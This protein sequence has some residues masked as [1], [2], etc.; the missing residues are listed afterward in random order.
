MAENSEGVSGG[1]GLGDLDVMT[2]Q[3]SSRAGAREGDRVRPGGS[4]SCEAVKASSLGVQSCS[5]FGPKV[6]VCDATLDKTREGAHWKKNWAGPKK[7]DRV[8]DGLMLQV[9]NVWNVQELL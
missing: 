3:A 1:G 2:A 5:I 7:T 6:H 9:N 4:G 8:A